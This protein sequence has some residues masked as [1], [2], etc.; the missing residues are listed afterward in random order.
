MSRKNLM[1]A[2]AGAM[3]AMASDPNMKGVFATPKPRFKKPETR[4]ELL[5]EP[6]HFQDS[7]QLREFS[8]KGHKVMAYSKKDAITRLKYQKKI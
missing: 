7:R 3:M 5:S 4:E 2:M 8:I 6:R 1:L